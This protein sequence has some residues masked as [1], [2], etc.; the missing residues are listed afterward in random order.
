MF[1]TVL[2][3]DIEIR[4]PSFSIGQKNGESRPNNGG[5]LP[6][7]LPFSDN[8]FFL[9]FRSWRVAILVPIWQNCVAGHWKYGH[10]YKIVG[11]LVHYGMMLWGIGFLIFQVLQADAINTYQFAYG[12]KKKGVIQ[13][14]GWG[15]HSQLWFELEY[16]YMRALVQMWVFY[17]L[18]HVTGFSLFRIVLQKEAATRVWD[19]SALNPK[20]LDESMHRD[21]VQGFEKETRQIVRV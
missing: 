4:I 1:I 5:I 21:R 19:S 6:V 15:K 12:L 11:R 3:G 20:M 9:A 13:Y 2:D 7:L 17:A 10:R 18:M 8:V 14:L 16:P